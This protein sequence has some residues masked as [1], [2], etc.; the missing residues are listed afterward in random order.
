MVL[1]TLCI[2][3]LQTHMVLE[4]YLRDMNDVKSLQVELSEK[5]EKTNTLEF[6]IRKRQQDR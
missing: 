6:G 4:S 1:Y 2:K 5:S 3:Y